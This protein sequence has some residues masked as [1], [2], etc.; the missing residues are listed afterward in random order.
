[1]HNIYDPWQIIIRSSMYE[2]TSPTSPLTS[3]PTLY[4][5]HLVNDYITHTCIMEPSPPKYT[6]LVN[7]LVYL[8][9]QI[10][11]ISLS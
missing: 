3:P 2:L 5:L 8:G 6:Y 4:I 11:M 10:T 1:M 9:G 7:I